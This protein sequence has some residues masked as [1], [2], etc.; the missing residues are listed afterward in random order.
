MI[1]INASIHIKTTDLLIHIHKKLNLQCDIQQ[2]IAD[3]IALSFTVSPSRDNIDITVAEIESSGYRSSL[4]YNDKVA[5]KLMLTKTF[6]K[7]TKQI[8]QSRRFTE[9]HILCALVKQHYE[10]LVRV[11]AI[12]PIIFDMY[13]KTTNYI[14]GQLI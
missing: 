8:I 10:D 6:K 3:A 7:D 4:Y 12:P 14:H 1:T 13:N 5:L 9:Y 2:Y 11:K